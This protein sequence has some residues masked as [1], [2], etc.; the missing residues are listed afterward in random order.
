MRKFIKLTILFILLLISIIDN[1]N[2]QRSLEKSL[3]T[4]DLNS[5]LGKP[6]DS[7][8]AVLPAGY[9]EMIVTSGGNIFQAGGVI[10]VYSKKISVDISIASF[11]FV[12]RNNVNRTAPAIA[13]PLE[14]M[15]KETVGRIIIYNNWEVL[16]SAGE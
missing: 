13:W 9:T 2:A 11:D 1:A 3:S 10:I 4:F 8:I 7:L 14:L 6:M 12:T 15:R 16:N 5:W